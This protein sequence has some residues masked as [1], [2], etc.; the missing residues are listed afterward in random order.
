MFIISRHIIFVLFVLLGLGLF[1]FQ[2]EAW[3]SGV[4]P[5]DAA[6]SSSGHYS[7]S[8]ASA[9]SVD[10]L[11]DAVAQWNLHESPQEDLS[12]VSY[13]DDPFMWQIGQHYRELVHTLSKASDE[14]L[15]GIVDRIIT[16]IHKHHDFFIQYQKALFEN[17][18]TVLYN[19]LVDEI[20]TGA[21]YDSYPQAQHNVAD[22]ES[23]DSNEDAWRVGFMRGHDQDSEE[24]DD[25]GNEED[26]N[27]YANSDAEDEG[28]DMGFLRW[29]WGKLEKMFAITA[30]SEDED[31]KKEDLTAEHV[32]IFLKEYVEG[33]G[34]WLVNDYVEG[35][36]AVSED[37]SEAFSDEIGIAPELL[38]A[39]FGELWFY[40]DWE[41]FDVG[42]PQF[43]PK[44]YE[45][46]L[47]RFLSETHTDGS[48]KI[49]R[50]FLK[51]VQGVQ[52]LLCSP[53]NWPDSLKDLPERYNW[54]ARSRDWR[55]AL[56]HWSV[57]S[58]YQKIMCLKISQRRQTDAASV[59]SS[60]SAASIAEL[61]GQAKVIEALEAARERAQ[62]Y[63]TKVY[64][65]PD[66]NAVVYGAKEAQHKRAHLDLRS[67]LSR[68][69]AVGGA[70]ESY[71]P[72]EDQK[73]RK[74][75]LVPALYAV[76][77]DRTHSNGGQHKR[78][79]VPI[80]LDLTDFTR[81]LL[82]KDAND[83]VVTAER[84]E[85]SR[86]REQAQAD[87]VSGQK[88]RGMEEVE[89]NGLFS[90]ATERELNHSERVWLELLRRPDVIKAMVAS[91]RQNV[92]PY[93]P[94][95]AQGRLKVYSLVALFYSTNSVCPYCTP[96]LIAAQNSYEPGGFLECFTRELN[97]DPSFKTR[98]YNGQDKKQD[99]RKFR[100]HT[101]VTAATN[102]D[103][104]AHDLTGAGDHSHAAVNKAP[105]TH[106]P[107]ARL[108]FSGNAIDL[109]AEPQDSDGKSDP[110]QRFFYEFVGTGLHTGGTPNLPYPGIVFSSGG[111]SWGNKVP[112]T[113]LKK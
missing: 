105:A 92:V 73:Q 70:V 6:A 25:S 48:P 106:N 91:L 59:D 84:T 51:V 1:S 72:V 12:S 54:C 24:Q 23:E 113:V 8:A 81:R 66:T 46:T 28:D 56:V 43:I 95:G 30:S 39:I 64:P 79:F 93:L 108:L 96:S 27:S 99:P 3:R 97:A 58:R 62:K 74:N 45:A 60:V 2:V 32:Q 68:L 88:T 37:F 31:F 90:K 19:W 38:E 34:S 78:V 80:D 18:R 87:Y 13:N 110:A 35:T 33:G 20:L 61:N 86:Y 109:H 111:E 22:D 102:F 5:G 100:L 10:D 101:I 26:E 7:R 49:G 11:E 47:K 57:Y 103:P 76:V 14:Q 75:I 69:K 16:A 17:L 104:Q 52:K 89:A 15:E 98:G 85:N 83:G 63:Y 71:R 42:D 107:D 4:H 65:H 50:K 41:K 94:M 21:N 82:T 67:V 9:A 44:T 112:G 40:Y 77:S 29:Q 53:D 55:G 36:Y